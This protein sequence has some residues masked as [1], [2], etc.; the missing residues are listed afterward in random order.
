MTKKNSTAESQASKLP[1]EPE[2]V[3][4]WRRLIAIRDELVKEIRAEQTLETSWNVALP[5]GG[6]LVVGI[7]GRDK[8]ELSRE[9][10][11]LWNAAAEA[12]KEAYAIVFVGYRFPETDNYAKH[13]LIEAIRSRR[14]KGPVFIV[15][16]DSPDIP[17]LRRMLY[18]AGVDP[19]KKIFNEYQRTEDF[20]SV[21]QRDMF[22]GV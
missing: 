5:R 1:D 10:K 18:W 22:M 13:F 20:L 12:I 21:F 9:L 2:L 15:L 14:Q 16:G 7:P 6:V 11:P 3:G 8:L 4:L 17:R 19:R